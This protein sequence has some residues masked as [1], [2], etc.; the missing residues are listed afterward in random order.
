MDRIYHYCPGESHKSTDKPCQDCAWAESNDSLSMAIVCDGHGG[1]SYFRSQYGAKFAVD[2]TKLAVRSFVENMGVSSYTEK[3]QESVFT[4]KSFTEY[5]NNDGKEHEI[6]EHAHKA[7]VWLFSSIISQW[8]EKIAK[9][10]LERD[11]TDWERTHVD[12]KYQD[13]FKL[14]RQKEGETF[15][16][17][18]GCTLMVYVQTPSYWFAF[19]IGDGKCVFMSIDGGKLICQQP[20]P[21]DEKCF[22]NK[23]TSLCDSRAIEEFRYCFQGNGEFPLAVFLGS[24]GLDDSFGDGEVLNNFYIQLYKQIIKSGNE[25]ANNVLKKSLPEISARG[26]K[27]DMSVACIY[28]DSDLKRVFELLITYQKEWQQTL[29]NNAEDKFK[30][31]LS[32]IDSFGNP[33][34]LSQ[35]QQI[36]LNYALKDKDKAENAIKK[37]RARIRELNDEMD[38][39]IKGH[40]KHVQSNHKPNKVSRHLSI[41]KNKK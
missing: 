25:T 23:T 3:G 4:N 1:E 7:L 11:L 9:D 36:N 40:K 32:K 33:E 26:S 35:D 12:Q 24:D 21:W 17:I 28:S 30:A 37:A 15:E 29:I 20:I 8:N 5:G 10:A 16:K 14:K 22:L 34:K 27:D 41:K 2:I 31:C 39:F 13:D 38:R 19:H 6:D 18:Y